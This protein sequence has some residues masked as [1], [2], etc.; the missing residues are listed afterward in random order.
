MDSPQALFYFVEPLLILVLVTN[1]K[2]EGGNCSNRKQNTLARAYDTNSEGSMQWTHS[3]HWVGLGP[4]GSPHGTVL[5]NCALSYRNIK[6]HD[7][8]INY[9]SCARKLSQSRVAQASLTWPVRRRRRHTHL[10]PLHTGARCRQTSANTAAISRAQPSLA[11]LGLQVPF[12]GGARSF[13]TTYSTIIQESAKSSQQHH[14]CSGPSRFT[15][16]FRWDTQAQFGIELKEVVVSTVDWTLDSAHA[17]HNIY[18]Y[19]DR[20]QHLLV[21]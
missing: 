13:Y 2:L 8:G 9:S 5:P 19:P 21:A 18:R 16:T 10:S 12:V 11:I 6:A 15:V 7:F 20:G 1:H 3:A 4:S 17:P 14:L